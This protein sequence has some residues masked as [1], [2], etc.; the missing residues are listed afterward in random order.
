MMIAR[1]F[2]K[3][4]GKIMKKDKQM[5]KIN[6]KE[7]ALDSLSDQAKRQLNNIRFAERELRVLQ[8]KQVLAQTALNTYKKVLMEALPKD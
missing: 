4:Q 5:V 1:T 3:M 2:K 6:G 7:F 8:A